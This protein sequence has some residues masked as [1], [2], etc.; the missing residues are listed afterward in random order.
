VY[1]FFMSNLL[2]RGI[3]LQSHALLNSGGTSRRANRE[4]TLFSHV[5]N[6]AREWGFTAKENPVTRAKHYEIVPRLF[7]LSRKSVKITIGKAVANKSNSRR[8][9]IR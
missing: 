9:V 5:W 7:E 8:G 1:R 2:Q 3:G 6:M 4:I